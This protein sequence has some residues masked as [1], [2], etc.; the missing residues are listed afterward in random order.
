MAGVIIT[1]QWDELWLPWRPLASDDLSAVYRYSRPTARGKR[2]IE[3]NPKA[4]SNLLVVDIDHSDAAL[5]AVW[6]AHGLM[7]NFITENPA[8]GHAHAVYGLKEGFTRT[9][10][11]RRKPLA[12]AAAVTEGLRRRVDGDR[13]YSGLLTKNP[14]HPHWR[15]ECWTD[16]LYSLLELAN[17]LGDYM[18]ERGWY[19]KKSESPI[20]LG[21]NDSIFHMARTFA[22]P[23][24]KRI[25]LLSEYPRPEDY[26]KLEATISTEVELLNAG[27]SEPLPASETRAISKSIYKWTTTRFYG[28]T[29]TRSRQQ[30]KQQ[31][32]Q[33]YRSQKGNEAK[34][35]RLAAERSL[36]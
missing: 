32:W 3:A 34:Q 33:Q 20:G 12:L 19:R 27:Y 30:E 5:R 14:E 9:E 6:G 8:N 28:W 22:Y 17:A 21:R 11:A 18:P 23:A 25:R 1:D 15:A 36:L 4:I 2:Y 10:Y 35:E 29:D 24:A 26:R 7:P 13:A 31:A 16:H